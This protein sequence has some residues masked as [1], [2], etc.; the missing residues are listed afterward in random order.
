MSLTQREDC[1]LSLKANPELRSVALLLGDPSGS[2]VDVGADLVSL[3][4]DVG[5]GADCLDYYVVWRLVSESLPAATR[6]HKLRDSTRMRCTS[7]QQE[8]LRE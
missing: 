4:T 8:K 5:V 3:G 2:H 1:F 6:M 7:A